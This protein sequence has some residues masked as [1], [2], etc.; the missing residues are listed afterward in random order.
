MRIWNWDH[1]NYCQAK[2]T[3]LHYAKKALSLKNLLMK[4]GCQ[5]EKFIRILM[6][7]CIDRKEFVIKNK[8]IMGLRWG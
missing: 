3:E 1:F 4:I 7:N 8:R 5:R 2:L 6:N